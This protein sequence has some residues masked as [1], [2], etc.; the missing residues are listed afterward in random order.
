MVFTSDV[1]TNAG[2]IV[3]PN[4]VLSAYDSLTEYYIVTTRTSFVDYF[5]ELFY[6]YFKMHD[7]GLSKETLIKSL[8]LVSIESYLRQSAKIGL[9]TNSDDLIL[10]D[11]EVDYLREIFGSRAKIYPSGGHCGN[12]AYKENLKYI[13]DF[14]KNEG[15]TQ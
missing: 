3:P 14:F 2:F 12:M 13:I 11:G 5:D 4:R 6:P 9:V 10:A 7:P 15:G 8:S 1:M